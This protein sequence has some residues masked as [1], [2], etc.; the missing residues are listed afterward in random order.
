MTARALRKRWTQFVD[1]PAGRAV[2]RTAN[3]LLTVGV[4]GYLVYRLSG[5]GWGQIW[6]EMPDTVWFY[7]IFLVMYFTLPVVEA[8]IYG[9]IWQ[10]PTR[11][12]LP[13]TLKKRVY[14][15]DVM[16]YTGEFYLMFWGRD[17]AEQTGREVLHAVKDNTIVSS[18]VST[19]VSFVL[20]GAFF[21][22][23]LL[24]LP[25]ALVAN[26]LVYIV[27][28]V[29]LFLVLVALV[30]RFRRSLLFLPMK[31]L[32]LIAGLHVLRLVIVQGAQVLQWAV[33]LP[34]V[35]VEI[36]LTFLSVQILMNRFPVLPSRDL[37]FLGV[38]VE[39]SQAMAVPEA[40]LASMLLVNSVMDKSLNALFFGLA[41]F[42]DR[43]RPTLPDPET[44][45]SATAPREPR[46]APPVEI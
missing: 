11:R 39:M 21:F 19:V 40:A 30:I 7:L 13:A 45:S 2:V 27:V 22:A 37:I 17:R 42:L 3:V 23:G 46:P 33:V 34:D 43:R 10:M 31:T 29:A 12:M 26:N 20:V 24:V 15:N 41:T 44:A 36:W 6:A 5:I 18:L 4:V 8:V 25:E 1:S 35:S 28:G 14:N 9:I 38:G 16:G 32:G